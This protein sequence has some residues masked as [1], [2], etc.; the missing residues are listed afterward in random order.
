MSKFDK[1]L[2]RSLPAYRK[3]LLKDW[4]HTNYPEYLFTNWLASLDA[5]AHEFNQ[6]SG[7]SEC[8]LPGDVKGAL[9]ELGIKPRKRTFR[10]RMAALGYTVDSRGR[11]RT[12]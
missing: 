4:L 5:T 3:Q 7:G 6:V 8:V 10:D 9:A 12:I 1:R 2:Y 11:S